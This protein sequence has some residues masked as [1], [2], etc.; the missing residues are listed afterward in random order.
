MQCLIT[1]DGASPTNFKA[2]ISNSVLGVTIHA[3]QA[4]KIGYPK[5]DKNEL[6]HYNRHNPI[7]LGY[8]KILT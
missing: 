4:N 7:V 5:N 2:A 1:N 3:Y 8:Y 6:H